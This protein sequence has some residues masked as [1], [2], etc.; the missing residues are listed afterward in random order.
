M[1]LVNA[2]G[3]G[4]RTYNAVG[5]CQIYWGHSDLFA[6]EDEATILRLPAV[7]KLV[8]VVR[9]HKIDVATAHRVRS[10]SRSHLRFSTVND[11]RPNDGLSAFRLPMT[12]TMFIHLE[13]AGVALAVG[14]VEH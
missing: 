5:S 4:N 14:K 13:T 12:A 2:G 10:C 6:F 1:L 8:V 3:K 7:H 11:V 9:D